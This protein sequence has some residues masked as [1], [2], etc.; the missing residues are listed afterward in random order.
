[1]EVNLTVLST[2]SLQQLLNYV[3]GF[4]TPKEGILRSLL[5]ASDKEAQERIV[6]E[7]SLFHLVYLFLN[8]ECF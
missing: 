6:E 5:T 8:A 1:M 7:H 3:L 4:P 2:I